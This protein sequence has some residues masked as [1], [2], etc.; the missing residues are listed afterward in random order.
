[1]LDDA[2]DVNQL[3]ASNAFVG[4]AVVFQD[5]DDLTV[6]TVSAG[7]AFPAPVGTA[8]A[9]L[10]GV[11]T[12]NGDVELLTGAGNGSG[13]GFLSLL[14]QVTVVGGSVTSAT[15][16]ADV[17]LTASGSVTQG[18]SGTITADELGVRQTSSAAGAVCWTT[19]TT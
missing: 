13:T 11:S 7:H 4:G 8:F 19:P 3:A 6:E 12:D 5:V 18:T 15:M 16:T 10:S 14:E 1:M 9:S 2:N 17:R